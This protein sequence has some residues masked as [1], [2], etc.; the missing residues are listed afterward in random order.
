MIKRNESMGNFHGVCICR[1][2]PAISHL[3]F[4]DDSFIFCKATTREV[5]CL[6]DILSNYESA[7]SKQLIILNRLFSLGEI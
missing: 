6:K 4:A 7:S 3:L 1:G 5:D 2:A